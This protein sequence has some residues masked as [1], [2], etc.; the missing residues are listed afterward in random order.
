M[1]KIKIGN[2][3]KDRVS[4][5]QGIVT[6][7][8]LYLTGC[9]QFL[10]SPDHLD[11]NGNRK[12]GIWFDEASIEYVDEGLGDILGTVDDGYPE[13]DSETEVEETERPRR[14]SGGPSNNEPSGMPHP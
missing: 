12:D 7:R 5:L 14:R 9:I 6:A 13:D 11:S 10:L 3:I 8:C 4:G 1:G 2:R